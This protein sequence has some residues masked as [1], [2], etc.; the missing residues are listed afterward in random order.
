[1]VPAERLDVSG[2]LS[3][4]SLSDFEMKTG[5][6]VI[7]RHFK[8]ST[9]RNQALKRIFPFGTVLRMRSY[10]GKLNYRLHLKLINKASSQQSTGRANP[11]LSFFL[12]AKLNFFANSLLKLN[13]FVA[14]CR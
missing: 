8:L 2:D 4:S 3:R 13:P 11:V 10:F 12:K 6:I 9:C 14:L 5:R 7:I 1:M